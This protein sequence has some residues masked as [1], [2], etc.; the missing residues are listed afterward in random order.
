MKKVYAYKYNMIAYNFN[1]RRDTLANR[2]QYYLEQTGMTANQLGSLI[3]LYAARY[4]MKF[5]PRLIYYYTKGLY[6]PKVDNLTLMAAAMGVST[7][8]LAG[9]GPRKLNFGKKKE[10]TKVAKQAA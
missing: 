1:N 10:V 5:T 8:W 6:C 9:Y 4:K 3:A 7:Q 2:M